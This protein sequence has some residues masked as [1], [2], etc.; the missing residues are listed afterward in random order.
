MS[1][2]S[3]S[4]LI[5]HKPQRAAGESVTVPGAPG[6]RGSRHPLRKAQ[7]FAMTLT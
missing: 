1:H 2:A 4:S 6:D 3:L 5:Q 7:C